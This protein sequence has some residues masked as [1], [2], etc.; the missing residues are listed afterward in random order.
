MRDKYN[1]WQKFLEEQTVRIDSSEELGEINRQL[2]EELKACDRMENAEEEIYERF[3]KEV[4]FGTGG[5]RGILGAGTN[6]LNLY[7]VAKA[8]QGIA[9][10]IKAGEYL[11]DS[12]LNKKKSGKN[13][14]VAI[15]YDSRIY[16]AVFAKIA[17]EV[18]MANDINVYLYEELMPTPALSFAVRHFDCAMGIMITA[19]HNPA[20]YNGYKVYDNSGC[21]VTLAAAEKLFTYIDQLDIFEDIKAAGGRG[22]LKGLGE[23]TVEAYLDAVQSERALQSEVDQK[24]LQA[25]SVVYTPL[26][27][28]GNKPVRQML[29]R[30]GVGKVAVVREQ[31]LPD[32]RF[33]TCP[34]PNPEK[35]EALALGL[36]LCT[37]LAMEAEAA[38]RGEDAPD[39]LLATDPDCD[40]IGLAARRPVDGKLA[41][42]QLLTGNEVGVLLLDFLI[43]TK[44]KSGKKKNPIF[45]TTIVSTRMAGVLA[46]CRGVQQHLTLTGFKFIGEQIGLLE[47]QGREQE[48][49]FGFEE[50]YGYLSGAY[51]RDKDAVNGAMLICEMAAYYKARG[52]TLIE[53]LEE[54]YQEYGYFRDQLIDFTFEGVKGMETM[55]NL[56]ETFR[57]RLPESF[58]GQTVVEVAD[59]QKQQRTVLGGATGSPMTTDTGLPASDVIQVLLSKGCS[60]TVRPSGTEP[61]L[62]IYLSAKGTTAQESEEIIEALGKELTDIVHSR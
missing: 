56:M 53:R 52:V 27:G 32:G 51:V 58:I 19:S 44:V 48:F 55:A 17:A 25:L 39:L 2:L 42:Y 9:N 24:A 14:A 47:N 30:L 61:K 33:P 23:E 35:K 36:A 3:Y 40:R 31:E 11:V 29:D 22:I 1:R 5:L 18:L 38:G 62:K 50:S 16:S 12:P 34:Y 6:R 8:T 10:Y 46:T 4:E 41:S 43:D 49:L 21:Q 7:T 13:P 37:E 57:S 54:L 15:A 20:K 28:A 26:N 45:V 60:F 59:Y